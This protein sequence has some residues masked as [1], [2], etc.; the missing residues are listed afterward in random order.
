M[1]SLTRGKTEREKRIN[2]RDRPSLQYSPKPSFVQ[3]SVYPLRS[4]SG[5]SNPSFSPPRDPDATIAANH[6]QTLD[7]Q[8]TSGHPTKI[9]V[10]P[11]VSE[12]TPNPLLSK[13][14]NLS[15]QTNNPTSQQPKSSNTNR[16]GSSPARKL[17]EVFQREGQNQASE[18]RISS[19]VQSIED[20]ML[21]SGVNVSLSQL[22]SH[23][24][25]VR[26]EYS[27]PD[28]ATSSVE[29]NLEGA[30]VEVEDKPPHQELHAKPTAVNN[31]SKT[32]NW[33]SLFKAQAPSK[34]MKLEHFPNMQQGKDAVVEL[35]DSD[36]DS[37]SWDHC[38]IGY[39]LDGKMPYNLLCA[40]ARSVWKDNAPRSVKQ[41]GACFFFEFRDEASKMQ[42]LEG[43]PYFFSRRYLVLTD[44]KRM[45][46]PTTKHPSSIPAWVKLHKLPLECW[47]ASGFSRIASSIGRPIHVDEATAGKKRLDF[48]RVCVEISANDDLPDEIVVRANG[49]AVTIRVEYQWLPPKCSE[50]K[51]FGHKCLPKPAPTPTNPVESWQAVGNKIHISNKDPII[52]HQVQMAMDLGGSTALDAVTRGVE[53][54]SLPPNPTVSSSSS[55][56]LKADKGINQLDPSNIDEDGDSSEDYEDIMA[57][58]LPSTKATEVQTHTPTFKQALLPQNATSSPTPSCPQSAGSNTK[59]NK[60]KKK[61]RFG[62][63]GPPKGQ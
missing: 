2:I 24:L 41:I 35:D 23:I 1:N 62:R 49:E 19:L 61:G 5:S 55:D 33:A 59:K 50:C 45:L 3:S 8:V 25:Q 58:A 56:L 13:P 48:A 10:S 29:V 18:D 17:H 63:S 44:W 4:R 15:E 22:K 36:V 51:V 53:S 38:L 43:G 47:T 14:I 40:T 31:P 60:N 21:K 30:F 12:V 11:D 6:S 16:S 42:V 9:D 34:T 32:Q 26:E 57:D 54:S 46:V 39:F 27:K 37:N 20:E 28:A 7:F 52:Q